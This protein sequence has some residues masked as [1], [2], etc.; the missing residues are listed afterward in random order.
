MVIFFFQL[1]TKEACFTSFFSQ[2]I[3]YARICSKYEDFCIR[4][5][6]LS[7][8]LQNQ[9]YKYKELRKLSVR[10]FHERNSLL[11]KYNQRNINIFLRDSLYCA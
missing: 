5:L 10:F 6:N 8:R 1:H 4:S 3:Q 9:G 2:L 11:N 7:E